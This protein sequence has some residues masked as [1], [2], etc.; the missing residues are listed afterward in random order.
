MAV[1]NSLPAESVRPRRVLI[2]D[3]HPIFVDA[4]S[5]MLED[6]ESFELIG[7]AGTIFEALE[8]AESSSPDLILLDYR[9]P[10]G[11]GLDATRAL[12]ARHPASALVLWGVE[13]DSA[14]VRAATAAGATAYLLKSSSGGM[15]LR[16][17]REVASR[18]GDGAG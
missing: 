12:R 7:C 13:T 3:D 10:D 14:A 4:L 16:T 9:L 17:L 2:V 8:L 11:T 1:V 18:D 6:D 5:A 15:V